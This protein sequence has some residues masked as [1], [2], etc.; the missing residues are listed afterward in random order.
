M[1]ITAGSDLTVGLAPEEDL[2]FSP[3][4]GAPEPRL[5]Q[6]QPHR[7]LQRRGGPQCPKK[8]APLSCSPPA[9]RLV[10]GLTSGPFLLDF[11]L[12]DALF[13]FLLALRVFCE[14]SGGV[15]DKMV[16]AR[17]AGRPW[18]LGFP[19]AGGTHLGPAGPED[20]GGGDDHSGVDPQGAR[21]LDLLQHEA[22]HL[23]VGLEGVGGWGA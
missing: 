4:L 21:L 7:Q 16:G 22:G 2:D 20:P 15:G 12:K 6:R 14:G 3:C 5:T 11:L 8:Q 13:F 9:A 19:G 10:P 1:S 23:A 18:G 17:V